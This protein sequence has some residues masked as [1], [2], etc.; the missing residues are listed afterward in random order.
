MNPPEG[1][2]SEFPPGPWKSRQ[3][4]WKFSCGRWSQG[5]RSW[6]AADGHTR[7]QSHCLG[8]L[9]LYINKNV[10][11]KRKKKHYT[12]W[13]TKSNQV[14]SILNHF[15]GFIFKSLSKSNVWFAFFMNKR[16]KE[17]E[18]LPDH[19]KMFQAHFKS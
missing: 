7:T 13:N 15:I 6:C 16:T 17:T 2:K 1:K 4:G 19:R 9:N 8:H 18:I 11:L 5:G 14:N 10:I 3:H 12:K